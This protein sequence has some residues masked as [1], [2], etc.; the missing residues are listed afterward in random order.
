MCCI[1]DGEN[2]WK[3]CPDNPR[4][5]NCNR[6]QSRENNQHDWSHIHNRGRSRESSRRQEDSGERPIQRERNDM[7]K[8]DLIDNLKFVEEN[9]EEHRGALVNT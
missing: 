6:G 5:K 9:T 3:N 2:E 7:D 8:V 4:N 1:H